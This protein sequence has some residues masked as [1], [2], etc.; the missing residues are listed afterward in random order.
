M[1][2]GT[3]ERVPD[4][5]LENGSMASHFALTPGALGCSRP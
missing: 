5:S 3:L 4:S 2:F 1:T